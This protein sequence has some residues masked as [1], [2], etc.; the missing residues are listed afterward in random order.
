MGNTVIVSGVANPWER[1]THSKHRIVG[2]VY[3][4]VVYTLIS[5]AFIKTKKVDPIAK[6]QWQGARM[7]SVHG[8]LEGKVYVIVKR[9][10]GSRIKYC[11]AG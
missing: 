4:A 6:L 9:R 8:I 10:I 2:E 3:I 1:P 5:T 11:Q 7:M